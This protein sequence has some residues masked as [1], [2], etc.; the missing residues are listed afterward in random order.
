M[1]DISYLKKPLF[2]LICL[3]RFFGDCAFFI[4]WSYLPS[5]MEKKGVDSQSASFLFTFLGLANLISRLGSGALLDHPKV[6]AITVNT[7][8]TTVAGISFAILPFCTT[9]ETFTVVGVMYGLFAGG[10]VTTSPIVLV[11]MFGVESLVSCLGR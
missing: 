10:Y 5:M 3:S 6:A 4:P 2:L 7:I 11:D 9:F 1:L 8:S